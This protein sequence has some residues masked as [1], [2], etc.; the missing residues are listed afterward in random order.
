MELYK[1]AYK[2]RFFFVDL[3][4]GRTGRWGFKKNENAEE[5]LVLGVVNVAN[6]LLVTSGLAP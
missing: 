5:F 4:I 3:W 2:C 6:V 1:K